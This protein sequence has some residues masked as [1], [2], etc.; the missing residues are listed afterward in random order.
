MLYRHRVLILLSLRV[1][2]LLRARVLLGLAILLGLSIL[3]GLRDCLRFFCGCF[4]IAISLSRRSLRGSLIFHVLN[5]INE[6]DV[7]WC[8]IRLFKSLLVVRIIL[9]VSIVVVLL[10]LFSQPFPL[11]IDL[12]LAVIVTIEDLLKDLLARCNCLHSSKSDSCL[13]CLHLI[14]C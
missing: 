2:V 7:S 14:G 4:R 9:I 10:L 12:T 5:T 13:K 8:L 1:C 6:F 3:L 11:H